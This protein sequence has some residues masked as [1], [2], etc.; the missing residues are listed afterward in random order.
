V[1]QDDEERPF[2]EMKEGRVPIGSARRFAA[3]LVLA[4]AGIAGGQDLP[5]AQARDAIPVEEV[6]AGQKGWG[7]SV[8]RGDEVERFDVEILGVLRNARPGSSF[9][10]GR[11]SGQGLEKTGIIAGMSGSPVYIGERLL[12]AVAFAWSFSHE[13]IAGITPIEDMRGIESAAPWGGA[14]ARPVATLA[15]IAGGGLPPEALGEAVAQ[16]ASASAGSGAAGARS[17]LLWGASGFAERTVGELGRWLPAVAAAG[18]A[19]GASLQAASGASS[20]TAAA[21]G[22]A[23]EPGDAVAEI[24]IDGDLRLAATGTVTD[25]TGD[26]IL[27]FGH[28]VTGLGDALMPMAKAEVVTVLSSVA[29]SFKLANSGAVVGAFERDHPSGAMGTVGLSA[30][31]VPMTLA[32]AGPA[33]RRFE[34]ELARVPQLLPTLAAIGA[35]GALDLAAPNGGV[36]GIDLKL[37]FDLAAAG[38]LELAQSFDGAGAPLRSVLY[39]LA[40]ADF[41]A[42][43]DL[44]AVE[45]RGLE[46]EVVPFAAPRTAT[47]VGLHAA[48][49]QVE[50][51]E[52]V[53]LFLD[54]KP[55]RG[56]IERRGLEIT[57]PPDLPTGRY[58]LLVGD[59]ASASAARLTLEPRDPVTLAQALATL[60][61]FGSSRELAVLGIL[62]GRGLA[63][64][65][66]VMPRLPGSLRSIWAASGTKAGTPLRMAVAELQRTPQDAPLSGLLRLDLDVRRREAMNPGAGEGSPPAPGAEEAPPPAPPAAAPPPSSKNERGGDRE[67]ESR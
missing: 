40:V 20:S 38:R 56:A 28:P 12:G 67:E 39:L 44:E 9:V 25:R 22:A 51:G 30:P 46:V 11:L 36:E 18:S 10:L 6:A 7:L 62:Q 52:R 23:L 33:P 60:R 63:V 41:L 54:L 24:W 1:R 59:G 26:R 65:G 55:Y 5:A 47:L 53:E 2:D 35:L 58:T 29:S 14:P 50:P 37:G 16:I 13:A 15:E 66:D 32:I 57:V 27:A 61:D 42:R 34:L 4:A 43:N 64:R 48:R 49:S 21:G 8:F 45:I 19:P 3:A 17:A 31:T